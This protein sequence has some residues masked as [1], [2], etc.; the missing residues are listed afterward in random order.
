MKII[1]CRNLVKTYRSHKNEFEALHSIS[2]SIEEGEFVAI[3]G[4]SG[5]GKSTLLNILG[6]L[7]SITSGEYYLHG[8]NTVSLSDYQ[9][10]I[11]RRKNIG[12]IFQSFNL[13][14]SVSVLENVKTPLKYDNKSESEAE[15]RARELLNEVGL[16]G[17][18]DNMPGQ[19]SGGQR[20]RVCIA[21]A[22]ANSPRLIIAD[23]PTGNLDYKSG[24]EILKMFQ[25]MNADGYTIIMVTHDMDIAAKADRIIRILDG[26]IIKD[27]KTVNND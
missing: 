1:D 17:K 6:L 24:Q 12:F 7:D 11:L 2:F 10:T 3:T 5:C 18:L 8:R 14:P 22:L 4:P 26:N 9:K 16:S 21:R 15:K 20:Q 13:L 23:E 25:R 27:E 19:L